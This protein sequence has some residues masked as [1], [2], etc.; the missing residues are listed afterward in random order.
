M[1]NRRLLIDSGGEKQQTYSAL[2]IH[3]ETPDGDC[4]RLARVEVTINGKS[5]LSNTD[6]M[7]IAVYYG[8]PT[9]TEVSY[10]VTA[11]GYNAATGIWIIP[12]E[13]EYDTEYVVLS[14]S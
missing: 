3:V 11:A 9:E 6:I 12:T 8:V 1:F 13:V 2:E 10:T 7:G 14:P 5:Y 4:V